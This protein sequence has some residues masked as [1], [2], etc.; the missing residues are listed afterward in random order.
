MKL[1]S[2]QEIDADVEETEEEFYQKK[3]QKKTKGTEPSRAENKRVE[4][5]SKPSAC[6]RGLNKVKTELKTLKQKKAEKGKRITFSIAVD[7]QSVNDI[8]HRIQLH[9]EIPGHEKPVSKKRTVR[10][11]TKKEVVVSDEELFPEDNNEISVQTAAESAHE[12]LRNS[13]IDL[14]LS[15]E[16]GSRK[17]VSVGNV[18]NEISYDLDGEKSPPNYAI[19][20]KELNKLQGSSELKQQVIELMT[21]KK[22]QDDGSKRSGN[23]I[24]PNALQQVQV[25]SNP[26]MNV[27]QSTLAPQS[28]TQS[29]FHVNDSQG[30]PVLITLPADTQFVTVQGNTEGDEVLVTQVP[31]LEQEFVEVKPTYGQKPILDAMPSIMK[32][33]GLASGVGRSYMN[34]TADTLTREVM[35]ERNVCNGQKLTLATVTNSVGASPFVEKNDMHPE[36]AVLTRSDTLPISQIDTTAVQKNLCAQKLKSAA[37]TNSVAASPLVPGVEKNDIAPI[38]CNGHN[39]CSE[40]DIGCHYE[41]CCCLTVRSSDCIFWDWC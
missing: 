1:D 32:N 31:R 19:L 25:P 40:T 28:V 36:L 39:C 33:V 29:K 26:M 17:V 5:S 34:P 7:G 18:G 13:S 4:S 15:E 8:T 23:V 14:Q 41:Q 27:F 24:P 11:V 21:G 20:L 16:Y 6:C 3:K 12:L 35:L 10:N 2:D 9:N 37:V 30:N 38:I 22:V